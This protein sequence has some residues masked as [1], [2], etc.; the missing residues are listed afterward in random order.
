MC[1]AL[2]SLV[3]AC[4]VAFGW[5]TGALAGG[6][7]VAVVAVAGRVWMT[8]G[9][10]VVKLNVSTG[11][12]MRHTKTRYRFPNELGASDGNVWASSVED[13]FSAGAVTRVPFEAGRVT[14]PLVFPTRPVFSLAVGSGTTWAL[15]GPW[16]SLELAAVNQA[17]SKT[18]IWPLPTPIGWIAADNTDAT[19]GL[20]GTTMDGRAVRLDARGRIVWRALTDKIESPPSVG[21]GKVWAASRTGLYRINPATGQ[22]EAK[23]AISS[24]AA[25]LAVGGGYVWMIS[26]HETKNG[27]RYQLLKIDPSSARPLAQRELAGPVGPISFG[28]NALWMGRATPTVS[29]IRIDPTTLHQRLFANNL[30]LQ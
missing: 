6:T 20:F 9:V 10:D 11:R 17:T 5:P 26:F 8:T 2:C 30:D 23:V 24:A 19:P 12:V 18:T 15:V 21:L 3:A 27:E 13:G 28:N 29:L 16:A 4:L 7:Q 22:I 14:H 1:R 25:E